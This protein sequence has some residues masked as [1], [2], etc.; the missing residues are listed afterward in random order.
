MSGTT[1][2]SSSN[3][4]VAVGFSVFQNCNSQNMSHPVKDC[5]SDWE[6]IVEY[7]GDQ[8]T[9]GQ[10]EFIKKHF[11]DWDRETFD[12][13]LNKFGKSSKQFLY[14]L[15][16]EWEGIINALHWLHGIQMNCDDLI[17]ERYNGC[18]HTF[19][20]GEVVNIGR[21]DDS[22]EILKECMKK[23]KKFEK[24]WGKPHIYIVSDTNFH[25]YDD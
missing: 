13:N 9:Q 14:E 7:T 3:I 20:F 10:D 5:C 24:K 22:I 4:R 17:I 21:L 8:F 2:E 6:S 16:R 12:R 11:P 15:W 18:P 25:S 1:C 23:L 19:Y